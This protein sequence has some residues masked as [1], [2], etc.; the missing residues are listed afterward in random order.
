MAQPGL[1]STAMAISMK[2]KKR[3]RKRKR[4]KSTMAG[5]VCA[6]GGSVILME[7]GT[8]VSGDINESSGGQQRGGCRGF[9]T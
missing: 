1:H 3:G 6:T 5:G 2:D 8:E 7:G 4:N 9:E